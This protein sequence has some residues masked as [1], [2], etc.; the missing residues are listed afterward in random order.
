[1][2]QLWPALTSNTGSLVEDNLGSLAGLV[3]DLV[4]RVSSIEGAFLPKSG[5]IMTGQLQI[6]K[7]SG[8]IRLRETNNP[9]DPLDAFDVEMDGSDWI[10]R[11]RDHSAGTAVR[12][13][14]AIENGD[15]NV[16]DAAGVIAWQWDESENAIQADDGATGQV[17]IFPKGTLIEANDSTATPTVDTTESSDHSV[18]VTC[19]YANQPVYVLAMVTL[20]IDAVAAGTEIR[21][22]PGI[23]GTAI[24]IQCRDTNHGA[25]TADVTVQRLL[26]DNS[27]TANG[28]GDL[29]IDAFCQVS[30]GSYV[31]GT[32]V[33][34]DYMVLRR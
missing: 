27:Q 32:N 34:I 22:R 2:S 19:D 13:L 26:I 29:V 16:Y 17:E 11:F 25:G 31:A 1:M 30:T 15:F 24:G 14:A 6:D 18:T 5:G 8:H 33:R 9:I 21:I 12:R 28:S 4:G 23:A 10:V 20:R 3:S 7:T